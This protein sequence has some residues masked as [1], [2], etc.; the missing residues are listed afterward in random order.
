MYKFEHYYP[1]QRGSEK[2]HLSV[3][4]VNLKF[5]A[6]ESLR[7]VV[8]LYSTSKRLVIFL[9]ANPELYLSAFIVKITRFFIIVDFR[10]RP[11]R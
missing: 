10:A 5:R 6:E 11:W 1:S 2:P 7:S 8:D 4:H 3:I 9:Y